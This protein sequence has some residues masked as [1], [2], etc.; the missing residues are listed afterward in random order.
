MI[1]FR[2]QGRLQAPDKAEWLWR[3]AVN[4]RIWPAFSRRVR[5][6]GACHVIPHTDPDQGRPPCT[7]EFLH[8]IILSRNCGVM[9]WGPPCIEYAG[10]MGGLIC[11]PQES[12]VA[13]GRRASGQWG[14][15]TRMV[16]FSERNETSFGHDFASG[17]PPVS[18]GH[19]A[20]RRDALCLEGDPGS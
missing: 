5:M 12:L 4:R 7:V 10:N 19:F 15:Q 2:R 17:T 16:V 20:S 6:A 18:P 13:S 14:C 3:L 1:A 8:S 11:L 9:I